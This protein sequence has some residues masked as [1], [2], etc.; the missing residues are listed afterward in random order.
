MHVVGRHQDEAALDL[1]RIE[2]A[3][4]LPDHDRP[5]M[6]VAMVAALDDHRRAGAVGDHRQRHPGDPPGVLLRR[7]R[8]HQRSEEHTSELQSLMR[9]SYAV[10]CLKK[11]TSQTLIR[12]TASENN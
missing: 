1:A 9:L 2:I 4:Q 10:F 6:L 8:D 5:F 12:Q 3:D 11:K 7:V